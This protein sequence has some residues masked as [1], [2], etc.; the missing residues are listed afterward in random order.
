MIRL[1]KLTSFYNFSFF[2]YKKKI[3][4]QIKDINKHILKNKNK[5]TKFQLHKKTFW[6]CL[7]LTELSIWLIGV[8]IKQCSVLYA[9]LLKVLLIRCDSWQSLQRY[10]FLL[11]INLPPF[12]FFFSS[13]QIYFIIFFVLYFSSLLGK[14]PFFLK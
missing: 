13:Q 8:L 14:K 2:F 3:L 4:V 9:G 5:L 10:L 7:K 11:I 12:L 1:L 6:S